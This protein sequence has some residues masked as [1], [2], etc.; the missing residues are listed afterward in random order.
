MI[1][2]FNSIAEFTSAI[3]KR[4]VNPVFENYPLSSEKGN[5]KFCGTKDYESA[6]ELLKTGDWANAQNIKAVRLPR[7]IN[8]AGRVTENR[9]QQAISGGV[10]IVPAYLC[11]A[12]DC[13]LQLQQKRNAGK[14]ILNIVTSAAYWCGVSTKQIIEYSQKVLSIIS[15]LEK[16]GYTTNLYSGDFSK[17]KGTKEILTVLVKIKK[18]GAP[19]NLLRVAYPLCNPSWLRRHMFRYYET[20]PAKLSNNFPYGYGSIPSSQTIKEI[21]KQKLGKDVVVFD[22]DS[23]YLKV[24]SIDEIVKDI[25]K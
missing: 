15:S 7:R 16:A 17:D 13:M 14:P 12:P 21:C 20:Y 3:E 9:Y 5:E 18:A 23:L 25:L 19:L 1:E 10:P 24:K 22:F 6:N 8:N 11:G 4:R 2:I